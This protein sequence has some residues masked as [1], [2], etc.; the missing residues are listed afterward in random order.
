MEMA[1]GNH[2]DQKRKNMKKVPSPRRED[3]LNGNH[4][5]VGWSDIGG[6]HCHLCPLQCAHATLQGEGEGS[7]AS[8]VWEVREDI[9]RLLHVNKRDQMNDDVS[10]TEL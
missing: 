10:F 2:G 9:F 3:L 4:M 8:E 1:K 5:L 6:F 7:A